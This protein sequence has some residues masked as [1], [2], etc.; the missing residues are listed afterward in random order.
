[1][2]EMWIAD[3]YF[4]P[5]AEDLAEEQRV[6]KV[7]ELRALYIAVEGVLGPESWSF[8]QEHRRTPEAES[9]SLPSAAVRAFH[10]QASG[11]PGTPHTAVRESKR[12]SQYSCDRVGTQYDTLLEG[13]QAR[14]CIFLHV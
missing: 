13:V 14:F 7:A 1:M 11:P 6:A 5:V 3:D 2:D 8:C 10:G 9:D 12:P 4:A